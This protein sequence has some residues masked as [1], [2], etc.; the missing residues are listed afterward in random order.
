[1]VEFLRNLR[2]QA[3]INSILGLYKRDFLAWFLKGL[4]EV[5][6]EVGFHR[7]LSSFELLKDLTNEPHMYASSLTNLCAGFWIFLFAG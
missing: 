2:I 6:V 3:A 4:M 7:Y 1:M 5:E